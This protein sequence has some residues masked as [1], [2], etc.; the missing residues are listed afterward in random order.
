[1]NMNENWLKLMVIPL[2]IGLIVATFQFGL[3]SLF[4]KD[5][6]LSYSIEEPKIY[7]DKNT[8]GD[9]KFEI[10]NIE[11]PILVSHS[12]RIWNSGELPI[13]ALP[14]KYL[15][16][17]S[18]STFKIFTVKHN[19]KPKYEFGDITSLDADN[20]SMRILYDLLNPN[21]EI[22][23][24]FLTNEEA[25]LNIYTKSE[26]LIIRNKKPLDEKGLEFY[27][28]ILAVIGALMA[29]LVSILVSAAGKK[30]TI[31]MKNILDK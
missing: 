6:E 28:T 12:V 20:N 16:E 2:F 15:F 10:N 21:D 18:S 14:V 29:M 17:N 9:V 25:S 5:H 8:I 22:N 24:I 31:F 26:G 23:I 13:K 27:S 11:T 19:T 7:I 1:M 30:T 4:E 3:P